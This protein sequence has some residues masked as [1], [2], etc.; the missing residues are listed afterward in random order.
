MSD[1][2]H[3]QTTAQLY[4]NTGTNSIPGISF[5]AI[6]KREK[7]DNKTLF[8]SQA[9]TGKLC[10]RFRSLTSSVY[11]HFKPRGKNPPQRQIF[12]QNNNTKT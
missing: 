10:T 6:I 8:T 5:C 1:A 9:A 3:A 4:Q 2:Q 12:R 7:Q 11:R